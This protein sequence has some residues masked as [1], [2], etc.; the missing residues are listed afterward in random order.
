MDNMNQIVAQNLRRLR[1]ERGLSLDEL[2]RVSGVSKSMLAQV[3]RGEG[4]PTISTLWKITN[5]MMVSFNELTARPNMPYE[6]VRLEELQPI[7]EDGGRVKNYSIFPG[8][9]DPRFAVYHME[10]DPGSRWSSEPH[11]RGTTEYITVYTGALQVRVGEKELTLG[12]GESLRF[13]ADV[14]HAY[15]NPGEERTLLHMILTSP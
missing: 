6:V 10:L 9:E 1:E 11:F 13:R 4:N 15:Q 12:P 14:P 3:E 5:G 8:D 2:A 7:L